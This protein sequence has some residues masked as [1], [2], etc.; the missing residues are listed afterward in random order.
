VPHIARCEHGG[1]GLWEGWRRLNL[2][3]GFSVSPLLYFRPIMRE[4]FRLA[5]TL[6]LPGQV[7]QRTR[8]DFLNASGEPINLFRITANRK[9]EMKKLTLEQI[10]EF[11]S[12]FSPDERLE[13]CQFLADL[14]DSG[15][16]YEKEP[17]P[18]GLLPTP[19][20]V[21]LS[22]ED[23]KK[24]LGLLELRTVWDCVVENGQ[25]V[26]SLEGREVFRGAFNADNYVEISFEKLRANALTLTVK[27]EARAMLRR[28]LREFLTTKGAEPT[29]ELMDRVES[30]ALQAYAQKILR[31]SIVTV[32]RQ[33]ANNLDKAVPL[34]FAKIVSTSSFS[35]ANQL[36][37]DLL[38]PDTKL[39]PAE[40]R[41]VV[42][43]AEWEHFKAM[44]GI[45]S[46]WGGA[47][48]VK[49]AWTDS[50]RE[51]LARKY[52][53]LQPAWT[54]AK[55]IA[56]EALKSRIRNRKVE[57]RKEVLRIYPNLPADLLDTF[58]TPR[59]GTKPSDNA[60]IHASRECLITPGISARRLK[61]V[62]TEWNIKQGLKRKA[63]KVKRPS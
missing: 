19:T 21:P 56:K 13:V 3:S 11:A 20:Q 25:V 41:D 44:T 1:A 47:R 55:V 17:P 10:K 4:H 27:D 15:I 12:Q 29:E 63:R 57:W 34:V 45:T 53:E 39:S 59:G 31:Q 43:G 40:I 62:V 52:K 14:P 36:R 51:C 23:K 54:D 2:W 16:A 61:A 35:V 22:L 26:Y 46:S 60:I 24:A 5:S 33:I 58:G 42:Y 28:S 18:A 49:H 50:D 32:A 8:R 6:F 9:A 37:D 7:R 48:N 30:E 38:I